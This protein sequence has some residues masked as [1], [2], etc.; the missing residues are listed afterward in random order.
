MAPVPRAKA[1]LKPRDPNARRGRHHCPDKSNG[2]HNLGP[3]CLQ[4]GHAAYCK[5]CKFL[6]PAFKNCWR[7]RN[8]NFTKTRPTDTDAAATDNHTQ[9]DETPGE[10]KKDELTKPDKT[11]ASKKVKP[12]PTT[13]SNVD[14]KEEGEEEPDEKAEAMRK[15]QKE[16]QARIE[17]QR[18]RRVNAMPKRK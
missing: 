4:Q 1:T 8:N 6:K 3:R 5:D 17:K 18:S 10:S 7:C 14:D 16:Q 2:T 9:E 12:P 15:A 13:T 11:E